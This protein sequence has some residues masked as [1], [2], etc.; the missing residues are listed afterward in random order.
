M[1]RHDVAAEPEIAGEI[2]H[3]GGARGEGLCSAVQPKAA[4]S[5]ASHATAPRVARFEHGDSESG[6]GQSPGGEQAG[7]AAAHDDGRQASC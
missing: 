5:V 3:G 1:G 2:G 7:N 4:N 6:L